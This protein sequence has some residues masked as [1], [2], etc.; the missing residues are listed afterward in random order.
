[1]PITDVTSAEVQ[2]DW[3]AHRWIIEEYHKCIKTGCAIQARQLTT[4]QRLQRLLGFLAI[5]AVK[6]LQLRMLSRLHTEQLARSVVPPVMLRVLV[7]LVG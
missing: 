7:A 5:V 1:V 4:A 6:L 2:V 3:Y